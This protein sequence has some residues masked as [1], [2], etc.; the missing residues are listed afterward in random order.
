MQ[1]VVFVDPR[2]L[3]AK[4]GAPILVIDFKQQKTPSSN[5]EKPRVDLKHKDTPWKKF[6][7]WVFPKIGVNGWF[8]VE[9]PIKMDDLGVTLFLEIPILTFWNPQSHGGLGKLIFRISIFGRFFGEPAVHF[10]GCISCFENFC[11]IHSLTHSI[12]VGFLF[13]H[14][15]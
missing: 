10:P 7:I 9:N 1:P 15:I 4:N 3:L 13:A 8:I 6:D 11:A 5:S 2:F 12:T 14:P